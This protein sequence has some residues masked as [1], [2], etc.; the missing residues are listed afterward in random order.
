MSEEKR[1]SEL[2]KNERLAYE[3][4]EKLAHLLNAPV[5]AS[6]TNARLVILDLLNRPTMTWTTEQPTKPGIYMNRS[7]S[8]DE[9]PMRV[10]VMNQDGVLVADELSLAFS[11]V[12]GPVEHIDGQWFGPLE[13]PV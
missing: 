1:W 8:E 6:T 9:E 3:L 11:R 2:P 12:I 7:G 10:R 4:V 13:P 5:G